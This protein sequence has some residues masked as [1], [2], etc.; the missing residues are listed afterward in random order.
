MKKILCTMLIAFALVLNASMAFA[1]DEAPRPTLSLEGM[2]VSVDQEQQFYVDVKVDPKGASFN[3]IQS[4]VQYSGDTITFVRAETGSSIITYF[5]TP[6]T[7]T[8]NGIAFSGIILG[9]FRGLIDPFDESHSLPGDIVRLVFA[10]KAKGTARITTHDSTVTA[11]DGAGTLQTVTDAT[12]STTVSD[13]AAP[14]TYTPADSIAPTITA[15]VVQEHDLFDGRYTLLFTATDKQSGI[16]HV[17]LREGNGEWA[18]IESPYVL[19][20]QSRKSILS[21]RAYDASGNVGTITI[22]PVASSSALALIILILILIIVVYVIYKK[23]KH[24]AHLS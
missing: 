21:L 7:V 12:V 3:G 19:Q 6:P 23:S 20:D 10:G 9:G 8:E 22:A 17:E 5:V 13:V 24:P 15:S 14:S 18:T 16:D 2:P 11:N 4:T 1:V